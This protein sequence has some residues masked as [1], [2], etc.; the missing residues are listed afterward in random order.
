M[1]SREQRLLAALEAALEYIDAI[2]SDTAAA[3]PAMPGFD[4]DD[5]DELVQTT[6]AR[7]LDRP[8]PILPS[9]DPLPPGV[10]R[11][12]D[13]R[14]AKGR[15]MLFGP[16]QEHA[17]GDTPRMMPQAHLKTIT[18]EARIGYPG[19]RVSDLLIGGH[20]VQ[21]PNEAILKAATEAQQ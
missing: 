16:Q 3:F 14:D 8:N 20:K 10:M 17:Y 13:G 4:R 21:I 19:S 2:P 7:I 5:V 6:R 12:T 15:L 11:F 18:L 1:I 9:T